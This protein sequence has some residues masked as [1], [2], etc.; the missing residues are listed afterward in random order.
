MKKG[1][2]SLGRGKPAK[3]LAQLSQPHPL[4][5]W[6][7]LIADLI[8]LTVYFGKIAA[9]AAAWFVTPA[10]LACLLLANIVITIITRRT[11]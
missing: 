8:A 4:L 3:T 10:G 11:E 5:L 7:A 1:R 9:V 2:R 6:G